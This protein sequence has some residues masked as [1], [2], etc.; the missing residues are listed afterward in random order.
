MTQ[1]KLPKFQIEWVVNRMH[2]SAT[3]EEVEGAMRERI[4]DDPRWTP[5][6]RKKCLAY[7]VKH[8]HKNQGLYDYVMRGTKP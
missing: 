5:S 3:D 4:G 1:L 7:A 6:M 2:V 8:H